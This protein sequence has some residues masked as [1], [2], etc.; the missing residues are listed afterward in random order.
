MCNLSCLFQ[1]S[2]AVNIK[3]LSAMCKK[4]DVFR[5]NAVTEDLTLVDVVIDSSDD[6]D[7]VVSRLEMKRFLKV[8]AFEQ[9]MS[10]RGVKVIKLNPKS[11]VSHDVY[12]YFI[13]LHV[14]GTVM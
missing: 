12:M 3:V 8:L 5:G 10:A 9:Y 11:R 13:D 4:G 14:K 7:H 6:V 1:M 2:V